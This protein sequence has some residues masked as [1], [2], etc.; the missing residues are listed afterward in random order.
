M[1]GTKSSSVNWIDHAYIIIVMSRCSGNNCAST[2]ET[3]E[4][5][6]GKKLFMRLINNKIDVS[7]G[8]PKMVQFE[9]WLPTIDM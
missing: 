3:N 6:K 1:Q 4:W 5:L 8:D 7:S 2:S 9:E